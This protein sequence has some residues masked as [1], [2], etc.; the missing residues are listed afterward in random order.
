MNSF[1]YFL[2]ALLRGSPWSIKTE[3]PYN[4]PDSWLQIHTNKAQD[5]YPIIDKYIQDMTLLISVIPSDTYIT[6]HS[7]DIP[8]VKELTELDK[9]FRPTL[10]I[11]SSIYNGN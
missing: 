6:I 9:K 5:I 8:I 7:P 1:S 2:Y 11:S 3:E 4:G 10:S